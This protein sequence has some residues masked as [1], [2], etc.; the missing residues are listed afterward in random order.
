MSYQINVTLEARGE[1]K[2]LPAYVRAQ[3]RKLVQALALDPRP[4][5]AKELCE[6]PKVY[7]IWLAGRWRI[8]YAIAGDERVVQVLRVRRKEFTAYEH[9]DGSEYIHEATGDSDLGL[10]AFRPEDATRR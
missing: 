5:R 9:L 8:A 7:R 1:I 3:A 4:Q 10:P 6:K 2:A